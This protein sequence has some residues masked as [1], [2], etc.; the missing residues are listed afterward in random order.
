MNREVEKAGVFLF[1][2]SRI[3]STVIDAGYGKIGQLR[4]ICVMNY[5]KL[6]V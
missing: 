6:Y 4:E 3:A 5:I 2:K 1:Q